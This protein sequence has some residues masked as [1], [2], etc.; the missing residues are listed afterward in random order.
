M[1]IGDQV[2]TSNGKTQAE[3]NVLLE[4]KKKEWRKEW[5]NELRKKAQK[6]KEKKAKG[7]CF[8]C[9]GPHRLNECPK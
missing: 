4:K 2:T 1:V 5:N 3:I 9:Q 6:A 8:T 7:P